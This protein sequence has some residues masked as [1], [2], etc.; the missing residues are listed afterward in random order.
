M[1]VNIGLFIYGIRYFNIYV[2]KYTNIYIISIRKKEIYM[3]M[4]NNR[5]EIYINI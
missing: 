5:R 3:K 4:M 2:I 1:H